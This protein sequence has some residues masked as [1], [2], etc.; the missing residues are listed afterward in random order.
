[1][2]KVCMLYANCMQIVCIANR[3]SVSWVGS[4]AW[5]RP[6]R[7]GLGPALGWSWAVP[8]LQ[9]GGGGLLHLRGL[10]LVQVTPKADKKHTLYKQTANY[11]GTSLECA[12]SVHTLCSL[13]TDF[14]HLIWV[15]EV[16]LSDLHT[17]C[18]PVTG[19]A[20]SAYHSILLYANCNKPDWCKYVQGPRGL[21]A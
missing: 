6:S 21:Y 8:V 19:N 1:M 5:R 16:C 12:K 2:H 10:R 9:G 20:K 11:V 3:D 15:C 18:T 14:A 13:K 7:A 17:V 4:R